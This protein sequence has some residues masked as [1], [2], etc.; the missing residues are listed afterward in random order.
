VEVA[1]AIV[2][3]GL[4]VVGVPEAERPSKA[5]AAEAMCGARV[6]AVPQAV[7]AAVLAEEAAEAV[8]VQ[9][10]AVG[11]VAVVVVGDAGKKRSRSF[12]WSCRREGICF[13]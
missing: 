4:E 10:V 11:V 7:A 12:A 2:A 6:T 1:Q 13:I 9:A 8:P 3:E 5:W